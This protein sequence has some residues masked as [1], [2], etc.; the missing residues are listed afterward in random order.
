MHKRQLDAEPRTVFEYFVIGTC[1]LMWAFFIWWA[2]GGSVPA[3]G[4]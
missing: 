1:I 3:G 2:L 4:L